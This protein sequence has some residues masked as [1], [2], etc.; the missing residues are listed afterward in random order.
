MGPDFKYHVVTISGIF[1]AL[2]I[3][4]VIGSQFLS[5]GIAV[6][7]NKAIE[8]MRSTIVQ[9]NLA[10]DQKLKQRDKFENDTLPSLLHAKLAGATV[11]IVQT[12]DY[13][14]AANDA[15]EALEM[16]GATVASMT[17]IERKGPDEKIDSQLTSLRAKDSRFPSNRAELASDVATVLAQG[18]SADNGLM[19]ALEQ[20]QF[21][22]SGP[23]SDYVTPVHYVVIV[24]G[25]RNDVSNHHISAVDQPLIVSLRKQGLTVVAC[26][27]ENAEISDIPTYRTLNLNVATI[28]NVDSSIGHYGLVLALN[29]G[30]DAKGDYG[31][32]ATAK[33]LMPSTQ[34]QQ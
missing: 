12:G 9:Q 16:A 11:A 1:F 33:D 22:T 17:V 13:P 2:A 18:D 14:T 6:R 15:R 29:G 19:N 7:T 10:L 5:P 8:S 27:P 20:E 25:S 21:L 4:M 32:K 24:A 30:Q 31:V 28:D 23:K 26:E 34:L 3:G